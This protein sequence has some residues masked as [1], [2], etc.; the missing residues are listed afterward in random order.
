MPVLKYNVYV[1]IVVGIL[2]HCGFANDLIEVYSQA[3]LNNIQLKSTLTD[4]QLLGE[5]RNEIASEYDPRFLLS[6]KPQ[7]SFSGKAPNGIGSTYA[8]SLNKPLYEK[9]LNERISQAS[10]IVRKEH[11]LFV[12]QQQQLIAQIATAYFT[13]LS[14][15]NSVR[16]SQF[17]QQT[18]HKQLARLQTLFHSQLATI[19]DIKETQSR[20]DQSLLNIALAKNTLA[21]AQQNLSILTGER[22]TALADLEE[23][24]GALPLSPRHLSDWLLLTNLYNHELKLA[25][26]EIAIK[27]KGVTIQQAEDSTSLDFFA[28]YEGEA[29]MNSNTQRDTEGKLGVELNIPLYS[30]RGKWSRVRRAQLQLQKAQYAM[31]LKRREVEQRV[32]TAYLTVLNDIESARALRRA[33]NSTEA[34]LHSVQ[35]GKSAGTR[36]TADVLSSLRDVNSIQKRYT[37]VRYRFYIN[38]IKLKLAAGTLSVNDLQMINQQ[39]VAANAET[40]GVMGEV[41]TPRDQHNRFSTLEDA[42][43]L[44]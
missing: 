4:Y 19:T 24:S 26:Y 12:Y 14:A 9:Q 27:R 11:A 16:F 3:E 23:E 41:F 37:D 39:L 1:V 33:V 21:Q 38:L 28:S 44:N 6:I 22:Y 40:S 15:Q 43:N 17:E 36:T 5:K 30:G 7:Y 35:L 32:K 2:T 42:W 13:F 25:Q 29:S 18:I 20:L 8:L 31:S 10:E 34:A